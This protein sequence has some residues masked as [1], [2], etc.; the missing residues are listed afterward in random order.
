M[1][2]FDDYQDSSD[3]ASSAGASVD[4]LH[5]SDVSGDG[6]LDTVTTTLITGEAMM[7]SD[8]DADGYA[9][10]LLVDVDGDGVSDLQ[11]ARDGEGYVL[12][13]DDNANG[14]LADD[15]GTTL[16]ADELDQ[17]LAGSTEMLDRDLITLP[18]TFTGEY[19]GG[20]TT[21]QDTQVYVVQPGDT[22]WDVADRVYGDGSQF[23][24]IADSSG[25]SDPSLIH[26]GQTLTIPMNTAPITDEPAAPGDSSARSE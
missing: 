6:V 12:A 3:D 8:S 14:N 11:V 9:D 21:A 1:S 15:Q 20:D 19:F 26:P 13:T 2:D 16:T 4:E 23:Q 17:T 18:S 5:V 22:L 24:R 25:I 7:L 10:S